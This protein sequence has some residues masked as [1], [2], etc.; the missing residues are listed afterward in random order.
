MKKLLVLILCLMMALTVAAC[1]R[2][3]GKT[4]E[5]GS[6]TVQSQDKEKAGAEAEDGAADSVEVI[7]EM[8]DE[9]NNTDDPEVKEQLRGRLEEIFA[10]AEAASIGVIPE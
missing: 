7:A 10:Q 5:D 3:D 4:S 6:T 9:F 1:G 8:V 2:D